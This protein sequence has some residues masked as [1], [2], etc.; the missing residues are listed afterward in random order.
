MISRGAGGNH[1]DLNS[2]LIGEK[3]QIVPR[4]LWERRQVTQAKGWLLPAGHQLVANLHPLQNFDFSGEVRERLAIDFVFDTDRDL[5]QVIE[6]IELGDDQRA[7][8]VHPRAVTRRWDIEP[9]AAS[10]SPRHR[11]I[12]AAAF[13]DFLSLGPRRFRGKGSAAH[14]RRVGLG[15]ADDRPQPGRPDARARGRAT[16]RR[17]R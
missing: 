5:L 9:P 1:G 14:A 3:S 6:N 12:F 17:A 7:Q 10:R 11:A 2:N 16:R 8:A 13:A 4:F 15:D